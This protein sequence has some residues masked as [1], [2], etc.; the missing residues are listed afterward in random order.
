MPTSPNSLLKLRALGNLINTAI[1][2]IGQVCYT[3]DKNLPSLHEPSTT[4]SEAILLAVL[5]FG[6][7][8]SSYAC[9]DLFTSNHRRLITSDEEEKN[10][11]HHSQQSLII[12]CTNAIMCELPE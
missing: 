9:L 1:D 3:Q 2:Q 4:E 8:S 5:L 7:D 10:S 6:L 12:L 11:S